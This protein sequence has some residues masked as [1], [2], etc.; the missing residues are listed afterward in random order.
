MR[1]IFLRLCEAG[2]H[3]RDAMEDCNTEPKDLPI[4]TRR[5]YWP[6][7]LRV[8]HGSLLTDRSWPVGVATGSGHVALP[9]CLVAHGFILFANKGFLSLRCCMYVCLHTR[10]ADVGMRDL[11][12]AVH[13]LP[14]HASLQRAT[15]AVQV[16]LSPR[17]K[18]PCLASP[19]PADSIRPLRPFGLG[20]ISPGLRCSKTLTANQVHEPK[21]LCRAGEGL[22]RR[23]INPAPC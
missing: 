20:R 18:P 16:G 22:T 7:P 11:S 17:R 14:P 3:F 19:F 6:S 10:L 9:G 8:F 13:D 15:S 2:G 1:I 23:A 12:V 4:P 21:W 5:R